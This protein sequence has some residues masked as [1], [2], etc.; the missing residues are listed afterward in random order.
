MELICKTEPRQLLSIIASNFE[1]QAEGIK[2]AIATL[3]KKRKEFES[4]KGKLSTN[5]NYENVDAS[6]RAVEVYSR[7][8]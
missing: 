1:M 7:T 8:Q 2:A 6:I 3:I 4:R 5:Q